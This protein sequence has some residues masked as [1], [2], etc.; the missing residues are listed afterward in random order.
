MRQGEQPAVSPSLLIFQPQLCGGYQEQQPAA[1][2]LGAQCT[3]ERVRK[4]SECIV[5]DARQVC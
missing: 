2:G 1:V 4:R 5:S 3:V